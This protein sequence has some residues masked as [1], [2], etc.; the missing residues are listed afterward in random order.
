MDQQRLRLQLLLRI[1]C[2]LNEWIREISDWERPFSFQDMTQI[3]HLS[4]EILDLPSAVDHCLYLKI[5][6]IIISNY[7]TFL[8]RICI[9]LIDWTSFLPN[10]FS[11]LANFDKASFSGYSFS[12]PRCFCEGL[13]SNQTTT[14]IKR[15]QLR[16]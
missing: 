3:P 1:C 11:F 10:T 13:Q 6:K 14:R 2:L 15:N 4:V 9:Y 5:K 8:C 7:Y 16:W 12:T